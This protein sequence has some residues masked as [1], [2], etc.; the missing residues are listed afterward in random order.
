MATISKSITIKIICV[1]WGFPELDLFEL[2]ACHQIPSYL[3]RKADPQS[4]LASTALVQ[5]GSGIICN[6]TS[7][8]TSVKQHLSKSSGPSSPSGREANPDT[9]GLESFRQGLVSD[10]ISTRATELHIGD[11]KPGTTFN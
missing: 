6:R 4:K 5:S 11:R 10:R 7:A 9:S 1:K 2:R 3:L 8:S